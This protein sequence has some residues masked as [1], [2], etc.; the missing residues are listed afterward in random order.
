MTRY[1]LVTMT[2]FEKE[3]DHRVQLMG[4]RLGT[5]HQDVRDRARLAIEQEQAARKA[6]E[7][8][9]VPTLKIPFKDF[10]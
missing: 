1:L 8:R 5:E 10:R 9:P 2:D 4:Y 3:I 7:N 6:W